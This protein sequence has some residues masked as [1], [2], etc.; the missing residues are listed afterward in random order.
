MKVPP[1]VFITVMEYDNLGVGY[2]TALLS[3]KGFDARVVDFN[4]KRSEILRTIRRLDPFLIGFSIIFHEY[5]AAFAELISYLRT[6]GI[7]CHITAGGHYAS[8]RYKDLFRLIPGID[9]IVRFEG[10]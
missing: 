9:T 2:M 1:V 8:L 6:N 3:E 10:E 5:I 4:K 7:N